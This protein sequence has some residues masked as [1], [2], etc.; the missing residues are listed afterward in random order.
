MSNYNLDGTDDVFDSRDVIERITEI[1]AEYAI[2]DLDFDPD[3]ITDDDDREQYDALI[4]FRD[5]AEHYVSDFAFGE[6]FVSEDY[7]EEYAEE[8][9]YDIGAIDREASWPLNRIDWT[10]AAEDLKIDYTSFEFFGTT[11]WARA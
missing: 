6:T 11:Y 1:E 10:A 4:A 8:M 5:E 9:A 2:N 3:L 7:F